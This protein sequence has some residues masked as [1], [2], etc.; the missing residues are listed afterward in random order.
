MSEQR[1]SSAHEPE[2]TAGRGELARVFAV[3]SR[4]ERGQEGRPRRQ[5]TLFQRASDGMHKPEATSKSEPPCAV[6]AMGAESS[7]GS[8][9]SGFKQ[10]FRPKPQAQAWLS[11][12]AG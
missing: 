6:T 2:E 7:R 3:Q 4:A 11:P 9:P 12:L 5:V 10:A 8:L 1:A